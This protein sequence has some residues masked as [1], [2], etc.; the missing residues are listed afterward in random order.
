ML[1]HG[2]PEK[3]QANN[4]K[5]CIKAINKHFDLAINYRDIDKTF[6]IGNPRNAVEKPWP[7]II[8]LVKY[9]Y[10]KMIFDSKKKLKGK[11]IA[12]TDSLTVKHMKR[13]NEAK[14][15]YNF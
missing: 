3:K 15:R 9:N 2:I 13:F 10:R 1:L 6:R 5:L 14:E 11:K 7:I 4:D 8:R 12:N